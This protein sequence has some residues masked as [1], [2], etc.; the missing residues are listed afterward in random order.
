MEPDVEMARDLIALLSGEDCEL[1]ITKSLAEAIE[2]IR[3]IE[4]DCMIVNF[5]LPETKGYEAVKIIKAADPNLR[6]IVTAKR[7]SKNQE[8][9]I[10]KHDIYYYYIKSFDRKELK[11]AVRGV[12]EKPLKGNEEKH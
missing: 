5:D 4:Y 6:I 11:W 10:R 1:E 7:N 2:M 12:I 9:E 3:N 8:A